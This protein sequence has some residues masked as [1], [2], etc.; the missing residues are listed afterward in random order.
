MNFGPNT[1]EPD[2][3]AMMD[4]SLE[5]GFNFF[6]SADVYGGKKGEG[7]T[8]QIVGRWF[9]KGGGR[10]D[11]VILATKV[12]GDMNS[13]PA[14]QIMARGLSAVKIRRACDNSLR[15]LQTDHIDLYQMHHIC[16][17]TPWEE[18]W[19][20]MEVLVH[21]GK[22][23]YCGSSNFAGWHVATANQEA[24]KR[25]F[26]GLV[27]EQCKYSLASR[28]VEM[29]VLPACKDYGLGVIPWSPLEGGILGGVLKDSDRKRRNNEN[30]KRKIE[31]IQ[32]Q[33]EKWETFCAELEQKPA[34]VA[35]AWVLKNPAV[36]APIIGPRTME[37]LT[38]SVRAL[39]V[40]LDEAAMRKLN[41][42]WPGPGGEAPEAFAW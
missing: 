1:T 30:A 28:T 13:D 11:K 23:L 34:D 20:A 36:T 9:A 32:P 38:A 40:K 41:E 24:R 37:Q 27:C 33:L 25:N 4:K 6:D 42:I 17:E 14:D 7:I 5:L 19:Q 39:D 16:R 15:R 21:Q 31:Q 35:L 10:R 2:A 18:I 22:I 26:L 12:Y 8:E 29:E 3:F